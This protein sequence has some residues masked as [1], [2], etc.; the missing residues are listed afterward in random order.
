MYDKDLEKRKLEAMKDRYFRPVIAFPDGHLVHHGD[1]SIHRAIEIYG[2]AACTCGF[3]HDLNIVV[4]SIITKL[5]PA[6][7][8]EKGLEDGPPRT[9][10]S[11]EEIEIQEFLDSFCQSHQPIEVEDTSA[12]D[13]EVIEDVFGH[14]FRKRKEEEWSALPTDKR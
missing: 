14:A 1:C 7:Y 2:T 5:H 13:W 10:S 8:E 4:G 11:E 3:L 12:Q 9:I 6:Y